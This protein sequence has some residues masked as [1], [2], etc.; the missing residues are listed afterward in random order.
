MTAPSQVESRPGLLK[1]LLFCSSVFPWLLISNFQVSGVRLEEILLI[2]MAFIG[3]GLGAFRRLNSYAGWLTS[4]FTVLLVWGFLSYSYSANSGPV[5]G[6]G[7]VLAEAFNLALPVLAILAFAPI[8][9][10][11]VQSRYRVMKRLATSMLLLASVNLVVQLAQTQGIASAIDLSRASQERAS[12]LALGYARPVGFFG[13]PAEL[14]FFLCVMVS[15]ILTESQVSNLRR[16][17]SIVILVISGLIVGSKIVLVFAVVLLIFL[18]RRG[19]FIL[20]GALVSLWAFALVAPN[21]VAAW[22]RRFDGTGGFLET[23][24]SGRFGESGT[25]ST[26][27]GTSLSDYPFGLGVGAAAFLD[28]LGTYVA[29]DSELFFLVAVAGYIGIVLLVVI[30]GLLLTASLQSSERMRAL[31]LLASVTISSLVMA[32]FSSNSSAIFF[33]IAFTSTALLAV[34]DQEEKPVKTTRQTRP[35]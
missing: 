18:I 4:A 2:A 32:A 1:Y 6:S 34:F 21:S 5:I 12:E 20:I 14:A 25:I 10:I 30:Y 3:V 9:L 7:G 13:Q 23:W 19:I 28:V 27:L 16:F 15:L 8:G 29:F 33:W 24:S 22:Q 11:Q 31:L 35:S 17:T 26:A